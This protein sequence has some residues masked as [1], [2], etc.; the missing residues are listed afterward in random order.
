MIA[1]VA[2]GMVLLDPLWPDSW[3]ARTDAAVAV[4]VL[5]MIAA[6]TLWM[7]PQGRAPVRSD[8]VLLDRDQH[9]PGL[10]SARR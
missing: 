10:G 4:M 2:V 9:R 8:A 6:M 1:A 7:R 5:D 3:T